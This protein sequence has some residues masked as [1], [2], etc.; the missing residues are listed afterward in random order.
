MANPRRMA[1][2]ATIAAACIVLAGCSSTDDQPAA[3][4]PASSPAVTEEADGSPSAQLQVTFDGSSCSYTGPSDV[5]PGTLGVDVVNDG[6][7][8]SGALLLRLAPGATFDQFV[9]EHQPEP[10]LGEPL[11]IAEPAGAVSRV[12]PG[13]RQRG[14]LPRPTGR[15]HGDR[16]VS[17]PPAPSL[18]GT[19]CE[20][21]RRG[22]VTPHNAGR[23][24]RS[25]CR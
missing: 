23:T 19:G 15:D 3:E 11:D 9:D 24:A 14:Q 18:G 25:A 6:D 16:V 13:Q 20:A 7:T 8:G 10:Y 12:E 1:S 22:I 21:Q 2:A 5:S 17:Q 4:G